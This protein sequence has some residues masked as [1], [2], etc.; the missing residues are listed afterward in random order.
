[1]H[2]HYYTDENDTTQCEP[3]APITRENSTVATPGQIVRIDGSEYSNELAQIVA[4]NPND[5]S[6]LVKIYPHVDY[7]ALPQFGCESQKLITD[8]H[9]GYK[10]GSRAF[11]LDF[12]EGHGVN[13]PVGE[14]QIDPELRVYAHIW[15]GDFYIGK[16]MYA[17][18]NRS[19]IQPIELTGITRM[20]KWGFQVGVAPFEQEIPGFVETMNQATEAPSGFPALPWINHRF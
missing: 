16:F 17:W 20:E 19:Y 3:L 4:V 10:P 5:E 12:F 8:S 9:P 13:L 11:D 7:H 1:M 2:E 15:D 14:L 18:I 6:V